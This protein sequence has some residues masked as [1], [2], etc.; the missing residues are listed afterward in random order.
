VAKPGPTIPHVLTKVAATRKRVW[1]K[2]TAY[3][4]DL[5]PTRLP[6]E[7]HFAAPP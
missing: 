4:A 6:D 5:V 1:F 2:A 7:F 3:H